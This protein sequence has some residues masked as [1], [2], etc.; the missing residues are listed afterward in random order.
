MNKFKCKICGKN[1]SGQCKSG[2]CASCATT[3]RFK[4]KQKRQEFIE[5]MNKPEVKEKLSKA[6]TKRF[7]D[8]KEREKTSIATKKAMQ[9][10]EIRKK[11]IGRKVT[12]K[13]RKKI[14][15]K[16]KKF[17]KNPKEREKQSKII[18]I[19][20]NKPEVKIK[21]GMIFKELFKDKTKHPNWQG[22]K[23]SL[24]NVIR[25][26]DKSNEWRTEVFKRDNYTCQE[27]G[28][29]GCYLEAHHLKPFSKIFKEFLTLYSNYS[30]IED[31]EILIN[32]AL[33][34]KDFWNLDNGKTLCKDCHKLETFV[35]KN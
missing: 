24:H 20:L 9:K 14:S 28:Q 27:C 12:K 35:T 25:H 11:I 2:L 4:D 10:P 32:F 33:N 23:T 34:Y 17:F 1:I 6:V 7:Q 19:A 8:P 5:T 16:L 13:T 21:R 22:G 29:K 15:K 30:P 26:C 3:K 18:T 31:K